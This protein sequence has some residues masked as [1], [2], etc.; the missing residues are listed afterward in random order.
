MTRNKKLLFFLPL[1]FVALASFTYII[2]SDKESAIDQALMQNLKVLHY[3][4]LE[5]NDAVSEKIYELYIKRLDGG[6]KFLVQSDVDELKKLNHS[7]DDDINKGTFNFFD[8]SLEIITSRIEEAKTYYTDVLTKP[9][10]FTKEETVETDGEKLKFSSSKEDLKDAWRKS[11]KYNVLAKMFEIMDAQ[12]KAKEKSDTDQ[13][14]SKE[15]VVVEARKKV[16]KMYDDYFKRLKKYNRNDRLAMYFNVI[17]SIY[18][19]HTE[20]FAPKDKAAF[21]AGMSGQFFGIGAQLQEKDDYIKVTNIIPGTPSYRQGQLKTGDYILKVA[22]GAEEPVDVADMQ[23][24]DV[25]QL[26]RGKKGTEVR[27]TVKKPDGSI[28]IIYLIRDIVVMEDTFAQSVLLKGKKNIGYIKLP[29]FYDDFNGTGGRSCSRDVKKELEKL[30]DENVDGVI[31]D[32]RNNGGGSLNDVIEM[33]GLFI[34][35]GPMVQVKSKTGSPEI[36]EDPDPSITYSGP[37]TIMVNSNSASASEIMAAAIQDYKRGVIVG[38]S[39]TTYGK[40]TVQRVYELDPS[41]P[42]SMA[43]LKPLGAV[44]VTMQKFYRINGGATQLRGVT[45]DIILPD[46]YYLLDLGE[47]E[48]DYPMAWDEIASAKYKE[49]KPDYSVKKLKENCEARMKKNTGFGILEEAARRVK[50]QKDSSVVSL[51]FDKYMTEQK[52]FKAESQKMEDLDKELSSIDVITLKSDAFPAS[53]TVKVNKAKEFQKTL[54]KD[55]YLNE[56][57]NIMN[58]MR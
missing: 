16:L 35:K 41:L 1:A 15:V 34:D 38:T 51:N 7:I 21:D 3:S 13:I 4:P 56:T 53:D 37:L 11:M 20:Y 5:I 30:K 10:D 12:Q 26:I 54:K 42:P 57:L 45:P 47:K 50:R 29:E 8:K 43:S 24:N 2:Q 33:A 9:M 27:L 18:D 49:L 19:P 6:K 44:K 40:G 14:K 48:S 17:T 36:K 39:P 28:I 22:Q 31:L 55:I 52:R 46:P 25:V 58:E 23:L 32:L